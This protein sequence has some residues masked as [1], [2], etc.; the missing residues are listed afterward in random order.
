MRKL[1]AT[2]GA[3]LTLGFAAAAPAQ[4]APPTDQE[5]FARVAA[6]QPK[7]VDWRRDLHRH[8]ELANRETR[9]A[10]VVAAHLRR[11]GLEVRT[12]VAYTGVIGVL[13]GARPGPT[14]ALRADMDA[15]PVQ[16]KTGLPFASTATGTFEGNTVPVMHACGHDAHVAMLMGAAEVLAGMKSEIAG[17]IVF[18]FQ[19]AEEGPP[20]EEGGGAGMMIQQGALDAPKVDAIFGLHVWTGPSG[21]LSWRPR[22]FM[23]SAD[24]IEIKVRGRQTHGARPWSGVD[25]ASVSAD[26]VQAINTI[27]ARRIDVTASPTVATISTIHMGVRHNIIPE[28]LTL[29]GTLR[30]F[31]P[32]R[33][34]DMKAKI[35]DA[36][37]NIAETYGAQA[38]VN[39]LQ[40]YPV[41]YND[42]PLSE[43]IRPVLARAA[44]ERGINPQADLVTGAEDFSLFQERV[45]GVFFFLGVAE[46]GKAPADV[47]PNHSPYFTIHEPAMEIG[48]RAHVLSA[49]SYLNGDMGPPRP[50]ER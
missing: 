25:A 8:P 16:E 48:V 10:G 27:S 33:R 41:T 32:E 22:G 5:I 11:L 14:V 36:V 12:G 30:T 1:F 3:V 28:D 47:A 15:L 45:P 26:I 50:V 23:A 38:E 21:Q 13:R 46:P 44:G 18:I 31:S 6:V 29:T 37:R 34:E 24:K 49:L 4:A 9:T 20:L 2:A 42:P 39:F 35:T 19:P 40:P 7:V 17:A 43:A